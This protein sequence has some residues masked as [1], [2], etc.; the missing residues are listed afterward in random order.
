MSTH[1]ELVLNVK[2]EEDNIKD[3]ALEI[4]KTLRPKWNPGEVKYLVR[5]SPLSFTKKNSSAI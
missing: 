1:K 4:L 3:G 2:I 5:V